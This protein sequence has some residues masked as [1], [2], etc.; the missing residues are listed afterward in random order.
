MSTDVKFV[1]RVK[2]GIIFWGNSHF[3]TNIFKIQ[4]DNKNYCKRDSCRQS[5]KQ[6]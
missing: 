4:K 6:L 2:Y 3:S 5:F 1:M